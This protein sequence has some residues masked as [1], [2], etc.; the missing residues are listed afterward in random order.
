LAFIFIVATGVTVF[1]FTKTRADSQFCIIGEPVPVYW[2]I[3]VDKTDVYTKRHIDQ[4]QAA[5]KDARGRVKVKQRLSV[6]VM[7]KT[8]P[9]S[10]KKRFAPRFDLCHPGRGADTSPVKGNPPRVEKRFQKEYESTLNDV[11]NDLEK[12]EKADRS[13]ILDAILR[14]ASRS[15]FQLSLRRHIFVVSDMLEHAPGGYSHYHTPVGEFGLGMPDRFQ[16]MD[17]KLLDNVVVH[18]A[19]LKR[20]DRIGR[21]GASHKSFWRTYLSDLGAT[22]YFEHY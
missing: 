20:P 22:V 7:D 15:E 21:Q 18:I 17:A 2:N 1:W 11:M 5:M 6:F 14:V 12:I 8:Y 4:L 13:P 16:K 9:K 3:L 19:Y 10:P